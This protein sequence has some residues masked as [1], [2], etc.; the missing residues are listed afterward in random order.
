MRFLADMGIAVRIVQWLREKGHD[1]VHLREEGLHSL[2][3]GEIFKKAV[4]ENRILLAFDLDFGEIVAF[5]SRQLANVIIFR[6]RNTRT[7]FI[8][9]RLED[10]LIV[11]EDLIE[12]RAVVIVEEA[13]YRVRKLPI[14]KK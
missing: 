1:V 13:R 12:E 9:K 14:M 6:L 3:N 2:P 7:D 8:W 5:S 4:A 10:V 11:S